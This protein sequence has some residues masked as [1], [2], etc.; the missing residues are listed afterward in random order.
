MKSPDEQT[1]SI[2][3]QNSNNELNKCCNEK[4]KCGIVLDS[5]LQEIDKALYNPLNCNGC[6][7][8]KL[9]E[10]KCCSGKCMAG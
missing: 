2:H 6:D 7:G 10:N 3:R 9:Y 1:P 4:P 5:F 8:D